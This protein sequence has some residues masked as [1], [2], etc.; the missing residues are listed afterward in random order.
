MTKKS[1]GN[2][3]QKKPTYF[4]SNACNTSALES[5][6]G[7]RP[8]S[9]TPQLFGDDGSPHV[10]MPRCSHTPHT[11]KTHNAHM[12]LNTLRVAVSLCWC[13]PFPGPLVE[14]QNLVTG[15]YSLGMEWCVSL[16]RSAKFGQVVGFSGRV[17]YGIPW[18]GQS[19]CS[20]I[21]CETK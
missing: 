18:L 12:R 2:V 15:G 6:R 1:L 13:G 8:P 7:G 20:L 19:V 5:Q 11:L 3:S 10:H 16:S 21:E 17:M 14:F 4:C 9:L